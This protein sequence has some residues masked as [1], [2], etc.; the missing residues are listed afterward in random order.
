MV[1]AWMAA[2]A[3]LFCAGSAAAAVERVEITQHTP[4]AGSLNF[5]EAGSY[6]KIR[7]VA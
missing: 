2:L 6:E 5:G 1:R 7:G 3:M 4:F